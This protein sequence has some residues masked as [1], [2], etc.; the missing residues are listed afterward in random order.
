MWPP[1]PQSRGG[2]RVA[3]T[4]HPPP[5]TKTIAQHN[6]GPRPTVGLPLT[7]LKGVLG[8]G[9]WPFPSVLGGSWGIAK[10]VSTNLG[11]DPQR[12]SSR[13]RAPQDLWSPD[14]P[15]LSVDGPK[16]RFLDKDWAIPWPSSPN[17][18]GLSSHLW[19]S[20]RGEAGQGHWRR[21]RRASRRLFRGKQHP[22]SNIA[23]ARSLCLSAHRSVDFFRSA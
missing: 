15:K 2:W 7:L 13:P 5:L 11:N 23:C 20:P 18:F 9:C 8:Q 21:G 16:L 1:S 17:Q 4:K 12:S 6:T 22:H 3:P 10:H 19:A 14:G